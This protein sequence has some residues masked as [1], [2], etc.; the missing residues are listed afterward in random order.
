MIWSFVLAVIGITGLLLAG[1]PRTRLTG[2]AV[3]WAAQVLWV[4]YALTTGQYGFL[5]SA[6]AYGAVYG[7]N[8]IRE[9]RSRRSPAVTRARS[10]R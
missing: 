10:V 8:V 4:G 6:F 3:G 1:S 9:A 5:L 7:G 2:W